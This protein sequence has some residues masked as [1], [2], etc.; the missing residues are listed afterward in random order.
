MGRPGYWNEIDTKSTGLGQ[1]VVE[2]LEGM[3]WTGEVRSH[4]RRH[5]ASVTQDEGFPP[6]MVSFLRTWGGGASQRRER[7]ADGGGPSVE[8]PS[9]RPTTG[10]R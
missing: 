8:T 2:T 1:G 10:R 4:H 9:V 7:R 3:R 5:F 6:S